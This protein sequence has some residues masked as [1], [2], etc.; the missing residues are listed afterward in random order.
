MRLAAVAAKKNLTAVKTWRV[1]FQN[2]HC[3]HFRAAPSANGLQFSLNWEPQQILEDCQKL[4]WF[5]S[6]VL[7]PLLGRNK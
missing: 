3:I 7:G 2:L 1:L 5:W 6:L 4:S